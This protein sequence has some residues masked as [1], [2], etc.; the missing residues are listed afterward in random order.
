MPLRPRVAAVTLISAS[1]L[2]AGAFAAEKPA[3]GGPRPG[4]SITVVPEAIALQ[5]LH[6]S[7]GATEILNEKQLLSRVTARLPEAR[8]PQFS[9]DFNRADSPTPGGL[10]RTAH[11]GPDASFRILDQQAVARGRAIAW[12]D[13]PIPTPDFKLSV[14]VVS[15]GPESTAGVVFRAR[16]TDDPAAPLDYE[17]VLISERGLVV[18]RLEGGSETH[19]PSLDFEVKFPA[20]LTVTARGTELHIEL[21]GK[22]IAIVQQASVP[23]NYVGLRS[24][25]VVAFDDFQAGSFGGLRLA[26]AFGPNFRPIPSPFVSYRPIY[27]EHFLI[28]RYGWHWGNC[29]QPV[30]EHCKFGADVALLPVRFA[31]LPPWCCDSNLCYYPPGVPVLPFKCAYPW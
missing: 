28:E 9:D 14:K 27:L 8:V 21:D 17:Y 1:V 24:I 19:L 7:Y 11:R 15:V 13:N 12:L 4:D 5:G 6:Q 31:Q 23:G 25:G 22:E 2:A 29:I 20:T 26:R 18:G 30:V 10:W 16:E 3:P